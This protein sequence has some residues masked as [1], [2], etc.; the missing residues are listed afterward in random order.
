[1]ALCD[2]CGNFNDSH[3]LSSGIE[4]L[5]DDPDYQPDLYYYW[6]YPLEEDYDW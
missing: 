4:V 3:I 1:M 5:E 6:D 2:E